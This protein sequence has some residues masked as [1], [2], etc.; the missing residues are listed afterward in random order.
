MIPKFSIRGLVNRVFPP[1]YRLPKWLV[2]VESMLSGLGYINSIFIAY[3]K[4]EQVVYWS[5]TRTYAKDKIVQHNYSTYQSLEDGN[6]GNQ[7]D[8]SPLYWVKRNDLFIGATERTKYNGRYLQLTYELNRYFQAQ[9]TAQS[10]YGFRQPPYPAPYDC[11]VS[12]GV[13]S[14]IYITNDV[15]E[16]A[17]FVAGLS[18]AESS[19]VA[20]SITTDY[21]EEEAIYTTSSG[22]AFIIH[23][24]LSV[25]NS[26][27]ATNDIRD[28]IISTFVNRYIP[29]GW[30]FTI[31]TY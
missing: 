14:D 27:G 23:I 18:Y 21:V 31:V 11:N 17:P 10:Y 7:P 24:P 28:S 15:P 5:T 30:T 13:F 25:Y 20:L 8:I 26:L 12:G 6:I 3:R 19:K 2:F 29:L 16:I 22:Y 9:L 1:N 4:G